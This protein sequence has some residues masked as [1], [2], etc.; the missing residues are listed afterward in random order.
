MGQPT[1]ILRVEDTL[2]CAGIEPMIIPTGGAHV[3]SAEI[4]IPAKFAGLPT[5]T[6]TVH[7]TT[8]P[9]VV[10][11]VFGIFSIKVN[12]LGTQ[13][14]VAIQAAN[15]QGGVAIEGDFVCNYLVIGKA[16]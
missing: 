6:G 8:G 11:T 7:A 15:A 9:G 5:V 16:A 12:D 2:I 10:G 14:Q 4:R 1:T 13:T 3:R